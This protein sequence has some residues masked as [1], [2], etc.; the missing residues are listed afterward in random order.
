MRLHS[1]VLS[2]LRRPSAV[3]CC[4]A[5]CLL[6]AG[7]AA[8]AVDDVGRVIVKLRPGLAAEPAAPEQREALVDQRF[9]RL[10]VRQ[11]PGLALKRSLGE[12]V[13]LV[14]AAGMGSAELARRLAA[15]P[16]VEYAE[17]DRRVRRLAPP[18]DPL[19][20]TGGAGGP[21]V[22]QWYLK[23]P[24]AVEFSAID[25][26]GAW[27]ITTGSASVVVAVLDT[28]VRFEHPDLASKLLP[29]YDFI[30]QVGI[31]ND[32]DGRDPNAA[33]PGDWVTQADINSGIVGSDCSV[34]DSSWH[35]TQVSGLIGAA[36]NNGQGMAGA[37]RNVSL[38]PVR[39][40]GKCNGFVS[41][42]VAG[43]RWAA[44]IDVG[45]GVPVNPN[46]ARVLNLSLGTSGGAC[47]NAFRDAII[48]VRARNAVVVAS[49][50][51]SA[52]HAVTAPANCAGVI[53]V[54]AVRHSGTKVGFS[55]LGPEVA[56]SAPGGN[57]VNTNGACLY[58]LLTTTNSGSTGPAASTYT[59][60][61]TDITVGTS[62]SAPLVS[63]VAGLLLS[64]RPA[65]TPDQVKLVLQGSAFP[66]PRTGAADGT[67]QCTA[68]VTGSNGQPVDQ[69]ECYCTTS[70]CGA[71]LLDARAA[72]LGATTVLPVIDVAPATP[73][74]G[75]PIT[76][77]AGR[78]LL[79]DG[80]TIAS[81]SWAIVNG[82]GIVTG[83]DGSSTGI[84]ARFTPSA[85]GSVLVS[86]TVTDN[87]GVSNTTNKRIEVAAA[88]PPP[89]GG[90]G[91][92]LGV[93]WL[94][95][96]LAAVVAARRVVRD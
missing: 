28:G 84:S 25:A 87:T 49:A 78:S 86:V 40:L 74:A 89:A 11:A 14:T 63:G 35:G 62:F 18:N 95:A 32:G 72:V 48:D 3:L 80:R 30:T 46:R 73:Q 41:D 26:E 60:G 27:D 93:G 54:A 39:V 52:G 15:D 43:M 61:S 47:G 96:L 69:L 2:L 59:D 4:A 34:E 6:S 9:G 50:G 17:P 12:R 92:A 24:N 79:Q 21:A 55:D 75:T 94:F 36:T 88:P 29:G 56:I 58:P 38:L 64:A 65:L 7:P 83:F 90:G 81:V 77:D 85:A 16:E 67:P 44:G 5:A 57:C 33:D 68:P 22:G 42:I 91:G 71:G 45:G 23:P 13:R 76:L 51:N 66:F 19:Y 1:R 8:A 31:A 53:A 82:G 70:T 10:G 37:G 20:A